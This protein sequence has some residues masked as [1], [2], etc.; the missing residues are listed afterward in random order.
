MKSITGCLG[1]ILMR[2]AMFLTLL[3]VLSTL[4][5]LA[6][7][8]TTETQFKDGS[9]SYEHTFSGSGNG[10]AGV[11]SIPYGAEVTSAQFNIRGDASSTSWTNFTTNDHYGGVGDTDY[12][13][14]NAGSPSPFTTARRDNIDVSGQTAYLKGNPT[15]FTPRFSSTSSVSTLGSAHLNTTGEF[16]ALGDQGYTSP[17]KKWW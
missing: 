2:L 7:G 12:T 4:S 5:P 16:V 14:S 17:T 11:V 1:L 10:T 13:S 9:T 15:E 8:A 3:F 6:A